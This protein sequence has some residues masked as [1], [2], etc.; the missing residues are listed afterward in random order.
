MSSSKKN[1]KKQF[2]AK[3]EQK[4]VKH[5][6]GTSDKVDFLLE[7]NKLEGTLLRQLR[8]EI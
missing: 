7:M 4:K 1:V 6:S 2:S 5:L 3:E 8:K